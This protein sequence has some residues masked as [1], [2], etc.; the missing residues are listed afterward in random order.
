MR[1]ELEVRVSR[2]PGILDPEGEA[3]AGALRSLGYLQIGGVRA[4][5]LFWLSVEATS[6]K[7]AL[8]TGQD[9]AQ[10]LLANPVLEDCQVCPCTAGAPA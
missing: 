10:R 5:R 4:G 3:V 2:R 7:E 9:L 6:L 8:A 1:F